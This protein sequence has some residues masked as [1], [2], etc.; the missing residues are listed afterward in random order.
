MNYSDKYK[1]IWLT[2]ERTASRATLEI[3]KLLDFP[4]HAVHAIRMPEASG[5]NDYDLYVNIRNPYSRM[6]SLHSHWHEFEGHHIINLEFKKWLE[7]VFSDPIDNPSSNFLQG[8]KNENYWNTRYYDAL[9]AMPMGPKYYIRYEFL[10]FDLKS[11]PIVR[12]NMDILENVFQTYIKKNR[13]KTQIPFW[14]TYYN[15]ELA[16]YVYEKLEKD[17]K[18]FNYHKDSWKEEQE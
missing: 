10:E 14:K 2:P 9:K 11:L 13:F 17:F 4:T 16:D 18:L 6:V 7:F 1:V 15:Q 12:D 3:M 5:K 8:E